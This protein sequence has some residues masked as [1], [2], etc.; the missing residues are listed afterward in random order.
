MDHNLP[1]ICVEAGLD[2]DTTVGREFKRVVYK[3]YQNLQEPPF[4]ADQSW[5]GAAPAIR[6][7]DQHGLRPKA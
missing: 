5:Q 3:I 7:V 6:G 2:V 1:I 4:V